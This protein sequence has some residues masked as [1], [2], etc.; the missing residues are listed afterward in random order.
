MNINR[1]FSLCAAGA[2][3]A[4]I[5]TNIHP[6][7]NDL[8]ASG[9]EEEIVYGDANCNGKVAMN[10]AVLIMQS[11]ANSEIYGIDGEDSSHIT[12]KGTDR[13]DVYNRGDGLTNM[14]AVSVQRYLLHKCELPESF[15]P[16]YKEPEEEVESR[17]HLNRNSISVD[18]KYAE[19]NGT[20]VTI[21]HSGSFYIDGTLDDGQI[22]VNVP[23]EKADAGTV[24]LIFENVNITG[25]N[26]PPILVKNAEKTSITLSDGTENSLSDGTA[27]YADP[28]LDNAVIE[29]KDDLTIKG[30]DAGTGTLTINAN[31]QI[32]IVCNNDLKITG[33]VLNIN[34]LNK[35]AENDAVK[36]KKSLTV[37]GGTINIDSE[38]DGLK[39]SKGSVDIQ[40]GNIVIKAGND[41][42]Q[43]ETTLVIS[44][45]NLTACGDRG[46]KS[47]GTIDITGGN[48][49]ATATDIQCEKLTSTSQN[50]IMLDYVKEWTKNNPV[51][52]VDAGGNTVFD[53]NTLKKYKYA[54]VSSPELKSGAQYRLYTGGIETVH[55]D[56]STYTAGNPAAYTGVNNTDDADLLYNDLFSREE[57]HNIDIQMPQGTWTD[58]LAHADEETYYP[59]DV[60]IDGEKYENVGI[61]T[62]GNSSR[63]FVTQAKRDKY[64]FRIK[65]N[66]YDKYQN[67]HGLT[68]ICINNMYSD[69]SCMRDIL[70]YDAMYELDAYA[71][72]CSYTD[73][74][75][76]GQLYSFYLLVEQPDET[77]GERLATNSDAVLYKAADV[78]TQYDC[79]FSPTMAL[80]NFEV[81]FGKDD[82]L[83]HIAEVVNEINRVTP[84]NYK[85]IENTI[86]V[87][88][89]LK[90]FAV[91]AVM[92]NYDSYNGMMPHNF[93]VMYNNGKM[94]Y[95]G[96]DYNLS[97]GNFMDNGAS[98]NSDIKTGMYQADENKRPMLKNLL[99]VPEYYDMY[100]GYVKEIT[101]MY[102]D[103]ER[104]VNSYA[105]LIRDHVKADPRSFFTADQFES[106]IARSPQGLQVGGNNPGGMW[107][108]FGDMWGGGFGMWGGGF[109]FGF[110]DSL[111]SYGGDKVSIVDFMIKRN[112]VIHN[113]IGY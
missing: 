6:A 36:A 59:C 84:Q 65:F 60:V 7:I 73:V 94:Y 16:D 107:G 106:N 34:T 95:V 40:G 22:Y 79:T 14:D 108:G 2:L 4:I 77:V 31:N 53:V 69:P 70:C 78:G 12:E 50:T 109:G 85:F 57:V 91:N 43:A 24:K 103:P 9:A 18:G 90:G 89:F 105:S 97:L 5:L 54:V 72:K 30:G 28:Y 8:S 83:K 10:D 23:D 47:V 93:Y 52:L 63:Q 29:A 42:V 110:G 61:R 37:K 44:G 86:D 81:K 32:G 80:N 58:F 56:G 51:T 96:W 99:Q 87:P 25:K 21:T 82:E 76:N 48:V 113:A 64:S 33:G 112:E 17:I 20:T 35:D 101:K 104:V 13:A 98:V 88:S 111:F 38:G 46:L 3:S 39:S 15:S 55:K 71:P 75:L 66:K 27:A 92:C 26:A 68:D 41:A 67:Y 102:Q 11:I 100:I 62:K 19:V 45:G 49:L 74:T 1:L